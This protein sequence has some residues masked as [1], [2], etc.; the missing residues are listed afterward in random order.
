MLPFES[1]RIRPTQGFRLREDHMLTV[2]AGLKGVNGAVLRSD[3]VRRFRTVP[4][5]GVARSVAPANPSLV[6]YGGQYSLQ[7]ADLNADGRP[8]LVQIGGD[9]A[10]A[11]QSNSFAINVFHQNA[12][13]SFTR[14]Q[15]LLVRES[16]HLFS[17]QMGDMAVLDLDHDGRLEIVV[18][19]LRPPPG[20]NGLMVFRQGAM[21]LYAQAEFIETSL[22][23]RLFVTDVD[24]DGKA[25]VLALG[26]GRT[27]TGSPNRCGMVAVLSNSAGPRLQPGTVLPCGGY[28]ALVGSFDD[29]GEP[30]LLM[31]RQSTQV[32]P[33][34]LTTR[35]GI[36]RLDAQ[37][38]PSLDEGLMSAAAQLGAGFRTCSGPMLLEANGDNL[39]E[40]LFRSCATENGAFGSVIYTRSAGGVY[41]EWAREPEGRA[42]FIADMNRDG[43]DDMM[44]VVQDS[45]VNAYIA[46]SFAVRGGGFERSHASPVELLGNMQQELV[47][48]ADL[49]G[50]GLPD[51]ILQS[52]NM[53]VLVFYQQRR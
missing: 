20:L 24:R 29:S 3:V 9:T 35:L 48:Q 39:R 18:S 32:P 16:Q 40:L 11:G 36:Y 27:F 52:Y 10:L 38:R 45:G 19:I 37:G 12:D 31:I 14:H 1:M 51:L 22:A 44:V 23:H 28:E 46:G 6:S 15:N 7:V 34:A 42:T 30:R 17:N 26:Q 49:D 25:D 13:G 50:D 43:L 41:R 5:E 53:G 2:K 47:T 21:G 4:F 33:E 8:D